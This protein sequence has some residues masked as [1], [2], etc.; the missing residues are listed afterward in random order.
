MSEDS[1][2]EEF[3]L[4]R[5]TPFHISFPNSQALP[6]F[7]EQAIC[8]ASTPELRFSM[9]LSCSELTGKNA[10]SN[11]QVLDRCEGPGVGKLGG[12]DSLDSS[13]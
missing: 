6:S 8:L 10:N 9:R 13:A 1:L 7:G 11:A 5:P 12:E 3:I 4:Q 2:Q